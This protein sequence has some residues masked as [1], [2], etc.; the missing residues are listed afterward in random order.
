MTNSPDSRQENLEHVIQ[1]VRETLKRNRIAEGLV[2][3]QK[4]PHHEL[5]ERLVQRQN[6][7]RLERQL[8]SLHAADIATLLE[9]L[10][11]TDRLVVWEL[12]RADRDGEVLLEVSD[13]VRESLIAVMDPGELL[14]VASSLHPDELADLA[15]DFPETVMD[16][17]VSSLLPEQRGQLELAMSY[18]EDTVG[19]LMDFDLVTV[20]EDVAL[21][22]AFRYLRRFDALPDHTD[23]LFVVDRDGLFQGVIH[24]KTLLVNAPDV[25]V[26]DV[27]A[28]DVVSFSPEDS[29]QDAA[30][31]F[32]RY[33]LVSAPVV[34]DKRRL[35]GRITIEAV[36]DFIRESTEEERLS[37]AGLREQEDIFAPVN[38]S[39]KNR[40]PWLAINLVTALIASRVIGLFEDSIEQLVA[41][42]AL[43]PIVAGMG[44]NIGN[45]T[46]TMI[47]RELA[48]RHIDRRDIAILY[49]KEL[50]IALINGLIWGGMLAVITSLL[51][52]N[53]PL[54]TVMLAAVTLTFLVAALFGV[55]IPL[56]RAHFKRDPALG[57]SVMIT[58]I[59]DSGGF[60]IFLGLATLFLL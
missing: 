40:A 36:I 51:Y 17:V 24:L 52:G 55:T 16:D 14:N 37:Q 12:V 28:R 45:Q 26:A 41:L 48:F 6:L 38:R 23:K 59:T 58:A 5:V 60:F 4:M 8:E 18:A 29:A 32:E 27:M 42:A 31:A 30:D 49:I 25:D 47:V 2:E 7:V 56:V 33:D 15:A 19:A 11:L 50:K 21:E 35:I 43:M 54:G 44:G 1:D 53:I 10:P 13:A 34:D 39:V 9:A 46:I 57:S 22:V 20:R 3:R